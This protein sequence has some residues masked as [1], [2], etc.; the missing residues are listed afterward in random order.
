MLSSTEVYGLLEA[1][2]IPL[3]DWRI[4]ATVDEAVRAAIEIGFPVVV[5]SDS[6][7]V[8]HKNDAGGVKL[9]LRDEEAVA[10]A[11]KE[12]GQ[13]I[14]TEDLK[15]VVQKYLPN[16]KE[17]IL[18]AKAEGDVGHLIMFGMGGIHVG[19]LK[20]VVFELAPVTNVEA[21]DMFISLKGAQLLQGVN[22]DSGVDRKGTIEAIQ[23]LSQLVTDFPAIR[24]MD[25]NPVIA[26]PDGVFVVDARISM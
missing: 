14:Q 18:G 4:A 13:R 1:Y 21:E 11:V 20:D 15:F 12:I 3:A 25:L 8:I 17:L 26:Y 24:E 16:G 23:R 10:S 6:R 5:K 2:G 9:D 22:G 19:I 7:E